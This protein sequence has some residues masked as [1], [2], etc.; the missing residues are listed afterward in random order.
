MLTSSPQQY[1]AS[2]Y[3]VMDRLPVE[4]PQEDRSVPEPDET[5]E[6]NIHRP[7]LALYP[8]PASTETYLT[9]PM[10][11]KGDAIVVMDSQ[12]R[13]LMEQ[14]AVENGV[15]RLEINNLPPGL[16]KVYLRE[17]GLSTSFSVVR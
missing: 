2:A 5:I 12:G 11:E 10:A 15:S 4:F 16:Y 13:I 7:T 9:W 17:C 14:K 8:N 1:P 6:T 3:S